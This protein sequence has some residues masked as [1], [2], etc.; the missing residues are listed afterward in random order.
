MQVRK[1]VERIADYL[2]DYARGEDDNKAAHYLRRLLRVYEVAFE[3][4]HAKT[5]EHS[6][7]AY[8][9]MIDLIKGK[10]ND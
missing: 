10:P 4:V 9:E 5:H 6:R 3:M 8:T 2:N 1:D 7:H